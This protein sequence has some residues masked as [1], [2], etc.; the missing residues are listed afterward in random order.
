MSI[1]TLS[2]N[3]EME[4]YIGAIV[5]SLLLFVIGQPIVRPIKVC[6]TKAHT[7]SLMVLGALNKFLC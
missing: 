1:G 2:V 6:I 3:G 5:F 7:N 4:E